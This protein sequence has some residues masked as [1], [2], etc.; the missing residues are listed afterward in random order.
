[1]SYRVGPKGQVVV[2]KHIRETLG[3]APGDEVDVDVIDGEV[4][5]RRRSAMRTLLGIA[6]TGASTADLEASRARERARDGA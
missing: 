1:M 5:I 6:A 4:R 2:P 3:I